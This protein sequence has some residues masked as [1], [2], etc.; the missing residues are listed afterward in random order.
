MRC[1]F[2]CVCLHVCV[3]LSVRICVSLQLV[4]AWVSLELKWLSAMR[5]GHTLRGSH[6]CGIKTTLMAITKQTDTQT[7]TRTDTRTHTQT[8][9]DT[10]R[11]TDT[12]TQTHTDTHTDTHRHTHTHTR[13]TRLRLVGVTWV[14]ACQD[15][16]R[17]KG[18][19]AFASSP[20][21]GSQTPSPL[22][23]Q[24]PPQPATPSTAQPL[25]QESGAHSKTR[26]SDARS[27]QE[28]QRPHRAQPLTHIAN[29]TTV[30]AYVCNRIVSNVGL[31]V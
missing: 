1:V 14:S 7:D 4:F 12:D 26:K 18:Q 10:H 23:S 17:A 15:V 27:E 6:C 30:G 24:P 8:H 19:R 11:H 21:A 9:T 31:V 16:C 2:T 20:P 5:H 22:R 28:K 25:S 13:T 29:R 3:C